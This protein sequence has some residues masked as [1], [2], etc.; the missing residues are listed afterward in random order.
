MTGAVDGA[1]Q[2]LVKR[3]RH[4][5]DAHATQAGF[6]NRQ[7]LA[8]R[9]RLVW[10][11]QVEIAEPGLHLIPDRLMDEQR[12]MAVRRWVEPGAAPFP[13][14]PCDIQLVPE[15][16]QRGGQFRAGGLQGP[17]AG[18]QAVAQLLKRRNR[19]L[20]QLFQ[21]DFQ[22]RIVGQLQPT[23]LRP[24]ILDRLNQFGE[25]VPLEWFLPM[26]R[27]EGDG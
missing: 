13:Q 25:H 17:R 22:G 27:V 23:G 2:H 14:R 9:Q 5:A 1:D 26:A 7:P 10:K 6:E 15:F 20:S 18:R 3:G 8:Q 16:A 4:D 12:P 24:H 19:P 21:T 11:G